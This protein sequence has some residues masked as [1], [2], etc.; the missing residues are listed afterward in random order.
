V[1][2]VLSSI[3]GHSHAYRCL[4]QQINVQLSVKSYVCILGMGYII[5]SN[6]PVSITARLTFND[7]KQAV[8]SNLQHVLCVIQNE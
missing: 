1:N 6:T 2:S 3:Q 4:I 8:G 7:F 5:S